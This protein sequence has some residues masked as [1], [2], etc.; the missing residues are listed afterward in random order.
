M[1]KTIV[2]QNH[3]M[4]IAIDGRGGAGKSSLA[5]KLVENLPAAAHIEYDWFHLPQKKLLADAKYCAGHCKHQSEQD[6][7]KVGQSV[8]Y[9]ERRAHGRQ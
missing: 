4:V 1:L 9:T 6:A 5:R 2:Q 3:R 8:R 7:G